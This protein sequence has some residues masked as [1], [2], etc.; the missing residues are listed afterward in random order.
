MGGALTKTGPRHAEYWLRNLT[1]RRS[2][3]C[4]MNLLSEQPQPARLRELRAGL[5]H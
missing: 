4:A 5:R 1:G 3:R 2:D